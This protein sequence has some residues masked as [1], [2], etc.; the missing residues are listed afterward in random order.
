MGG[1]TNE[2]LMI[3]R[4]LF[5]NDTFIFCGNDPKQLSYLKCVLLCFE[6]I[7]G[8][9]I[10]LSKSKM[11][12]IGEIPDVAALVAILG[13]KISALPMKNLWLPL[14][15]RYKSKAIWDP[16]LEKMKRKLAGFTYQKEAESP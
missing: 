4:L 9:K 3:S 2:P 14:G 6:T 13:C 12:R 8:L 15:A 11:V 1:R 16:I 10:N 7:F 5:A